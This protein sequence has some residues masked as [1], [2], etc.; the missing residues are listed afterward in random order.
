MQQ[1]QTQQSIKGLRKLVGN[2]PVCFL[3]LSH[4]NKSSTKPPISS[5][6]L[7]HQ[8]VRRFQT[9]I[10]FSIFLGGSLWEEIGFGGRK[11]YIGELVSL[12]VSRD[13]MQRAQRDSIISHSCDW[14]LLVCS[15]NSWSFKENS[16][17]EPRG[18]SAPPP[19]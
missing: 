17:L 16:S 6:I 18:V 5:V 12:F 8:L 14:S 15:R 9:L 7:F 19:T 1:H 11:S 4:S 13:G 3:S 10:Y 2:L